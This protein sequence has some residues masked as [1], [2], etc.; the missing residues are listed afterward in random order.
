MT[1]AKSR[2]VWVYAIAFVVAAVLC[3]GYDMYIGAVGKYWW[4]SAFW[5]IL[6]GVPGCALASHLVR[7]L[8]HRE[9]PGATGGS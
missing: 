2:V 5:I 7:T 4:D 9:R 8:R 3:I 1:I 6:I